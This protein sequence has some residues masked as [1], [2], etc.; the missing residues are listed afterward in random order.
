VSTADLSLEQ[1]VAL[2]SPEEQE[3]V[4]AALTEDQLEELPWDWHWG[5]RP[6]QILPVGPMG[7]PEHDW[8]LALLNAGRGWGK[9]LSGSQY[10]R[11]I[12]EKWPTL[13]RDPGQQLRV[14][15]LGRT[16]ADVRDTILNGQSGL[17][18]I[19]PPSLQDQI[20]WIS[21]QRRVNLP[22]GGFAL[23]FSAEEPDQ[24]RGP[25]FHVG[26]GDEIAAYKQ[27]KGQGELDAWTNL[28]IATRLGQLPQLIATTTPKRVPILRAL[29]AEIAENVG[30]ML[31]R[32]GK[33]TDNV[34]LSQTYLN[35]LFALYGGTTLGAQE[36]DGLMLDSVE[37]ATVD[38]E[39]ID[40]HRVQALP[41]LGTRWVK[42]ISV[43]PSVAEKPNDECG[44]V[45]IY[46]PLTSP[47]LNRHAYVV[48]D[49]S[50]K[51]S[52][53][54]WGDRVVKAAHKHGATVI[55]ENNQGGSLVRRV[56]KECAASADVPPPNIREVWSTKAKAIRA[57]P[58][59]AAYQRGRVHHLH[60][61]PD[62][63]D[64]LTAWTP[65]DS[66]YS[67]D[68]LDAVVHGLSA[69]LFPQSLVK[70]GVPGAASH[71]TPVGQRLETHTSAARRRVPVR[72]ALG[73]TAAARARPGGQF[74]G[75]PGFGSTVTVPRRTR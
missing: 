46:A 22:H 48:Q 27:V 42:I 18:N 50:L 29:L 33:T 13:G 1:T 71:Q 52:P 9:T 3:E 51:G 28:R 74:G 54:V 67:P 43:D 61:H 30:K 20:E 58:I 53:T 45:V 72:T 19:Y 26:W 37:G 12:D 64:Q 40:A 2:M 17:L 41:K 75:F 36:L 7:T 62:L 56:L 8:E 55:V 49:L 34:K 25:Q 31:L 21:T 4:L 6:S 23:C 73:A 38:M 65:T 47:I 15:L 63:E 10:I 57:E 35:T 11:E 44:I 70:G 32:T 66:G 69:V 39:T 59:G 60:S 14:A 5:G 68:R 24:L 16:A